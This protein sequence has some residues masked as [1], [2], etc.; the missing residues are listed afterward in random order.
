MQPS[1]ACGR[2]L[3]GSSCKH[4][5]WSFLENFGMIWFCSGMA[6]SKSLWGQRLPPCNSQ[7]QSKD[8]IGVRG[9]IGKSKRGELSVFPREVKLLSPCLHMLPKDYSGRRVPGNCTSRWSWPFPSGL[10]MSLAGLKDQE[11]RYRKSTMEK[12][13]ADAFFNLVGFL[14]FAISKT[15]S[16]FC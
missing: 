12:H 9:V 14:R 5:S 13:S 1:N 4:S 8:I 7:R 3:Q 15:L 16:S 6:A 2:R 10:C 11:T